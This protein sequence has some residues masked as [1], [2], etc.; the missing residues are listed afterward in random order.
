MPQSNTTKLRKYHCNPPPPPA[1]VT[2]QIVTSATFPHKKWNNVD[3]VDFNN[4]WM[5]P[6][7]S[8]KVE[9][10]QW[11]GSKAPNQQ[12]GYPNYGNT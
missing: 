12:Q 5:F 8:K 10:I 2:C 7:T 4:Y 11:M 9:N 1:E 6:G 3:I